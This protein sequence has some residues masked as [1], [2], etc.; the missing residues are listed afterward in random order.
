LKV[1]RPPSAYNLFVKE[2]F[3]ILKNEDLT[4]QE[5]MI[6][7]SHRWRTRDTEN[8]CDIMKKYINII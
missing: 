1:K 8:R 4:P 6:M 7:C 5:K 2:Q 3:E